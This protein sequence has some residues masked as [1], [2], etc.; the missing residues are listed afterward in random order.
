MISIQDEKKLSIFYRK[1]LRRIFGPIKE[2]DIWRIRHNRELYELFREV[3]VEFQ[4]KFE[5]HY[6]VHY[7]K[8][9]IVVIVGHS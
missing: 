1:I 4:V 7:P 8:V 9:K 2:G 6:V 5:D 3:P